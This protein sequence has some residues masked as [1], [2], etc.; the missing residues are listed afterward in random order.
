MGSAHWPDN[1]QEGIARILVRQNL[2]NTTTTGTSPKVSVKT[3]AQPTTTSPSTTRPEPTLFPT[4]NED[5]V[6][7]KD[8]APVTTTHGAITAIIS[9]KP[10]TLDYTGEVLPLKTLANHKPAPS[11]FRNA[12]LAALASD[13]QT[14]LF[15]DLLALAPSVFEGLE[16]GK[17]YYIFAPTTEFVVE[18]L[19][20]HQA[21]P[22]RLARRKVLVD[23]YTSQQFAEKPK[24]APDISEVPSTLN[25]TL[26][27]ETKYVDLGPGEAARVVSN[28]L[29]GGNGGVEIISGFGNSTLVEPGDIPFEGG[30]IKKCNGFF[31]LPRALETVFANT[32]GRLW[33]AALEKAGILKDLSET[34]KATIFTVEDS[35]IDEANL[36]GSADLNRLIH[37]GLSYEPDLSHELCLSTRGYGSLFITRGGGGTLVNGVRVTKPNVIAKNCVIHYLEKIPPVATCTP[38][39]SAGSTAAVPKAA[40][41]ALSVASLAV[42]VWM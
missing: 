31:T 32:K 2:R 5:S 40:V 16:E 34:R 26:V 1:R 3:T 37:N 41:L 24:G 28:P 19:R 17:E 11:S 21:D 9:N 13:D 15:R 12:A 8:A 18:F 29:G 38:K 4:V 39:K 22:Q 7:P 27:G 42:H 10:V 6:A 36:P 33:S 14:K 20:V 23:P 25:T 35:K 30:V